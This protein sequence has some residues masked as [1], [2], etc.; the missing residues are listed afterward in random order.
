MTETENEPTTTAFDENN[1]NETTAQQDSKPFKRKPS[2]IRGMFGEY[3]DSEAWINATKDF[4]N[5]VPR[6]ESREDCV[7]FMEDYCTNNGGSNPSIPHLMHIF[8]MLVSWEQIESILIPAIKQA[9]KEP[10]TAEVIPRNY[11][12]DGN[13]PEDSENVYEQPEA[14][15]VLNDINF[16]LNLPFHK[17]TSPKSTMNTLHYLFFHMKCGIFVMIR[18]SK[19]RIFAPFV[20]SD[21]RNT[22]GERL[23]V[24]G[25]GTLTAYY[26]AKD[27]HYRREEIEPD[28]GKWWANGNIICNELSKPED[29]KRIQFWGDHFLSPLRDMLEEACRLRSLPD[30]EFFLNKRDYP[31]LKVNVDKGRTYFDKIHLRLFY[32]FKNGLTF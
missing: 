15:A 19:L 18:N 22:W 25:D 3:G 32:E 26:A 27:G 6:F 4:P 12:E 21:Y 23:T 16:R 29:K 10:S 17:C 31:Q 13:Y 7:A 28:M 24:E 2:E 30:C 5:K 11:C 8:T 14:E 9:R 1:N 20:N